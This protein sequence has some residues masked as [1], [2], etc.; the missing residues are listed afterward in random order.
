MKKLQYIILFLAIGLITK[1][2]YY[3]VINLNTDKF[4]LL[5]ADVRAIGSITDSLEISLTDIQI[6]ENNDLITPIEFSAPESSI[7]PLSITIVLDNSASMKGFK[8]DILKQTAKTF[9]QNLPLEVTEVAVATF[10]SQI[11]LW[12]DFTHNAIKLNDAIDKMTPKGGTDFNSAFLTPYFGTIDIAKLGKYRRVVIFITD[13]LSDADV[14]KITNKAI[15]DSIEINCI[16]IGLPMSD[17]LKDIANLTGG[18]HYSELINGNEIKLAFEK[19]YHNIQKT[20]YG[21]L[22]WNSK[23][24]CFPEKEITITIKGQP[25]TFKFNI[26]TSQLGKIEVIPS[27]LIFNSKKAQDKTILIKG[28]NTELKISSI[29]STNESIFNAS[30]NYFPITANANQLIPITLTYQPIDTIFNIGTFNFVNENC[31]DLTVS[32]SNSGKKKLKILTPTAD[33]IYARNDSINISWKGI[34]LSTPVDFYYQIEGN[35]DWKKSV[36][37]THYKTT[38][39]APNTNKKIRIKGL[40]T[41]NINS[42]NLYN[43]PNVI[44][45]ESGFTS[46]QV[47]KTSSQILTTNAAGV[48]ESW[49]SKTGQR[50]NTFE[51]SDKGYT[52]FYPN[53]KRV[54]SF[55]ENQFDIFTNRNGL[56]VKNISL[57][58]KKVLSSYCYIDGQEFYTS[59]HDSENSIWDPSQNI[60]IQSISGGPYDEAA[61]SSNGKYFICRKGDKLHVFQNNPIKKILAVKTDEGFKKVILHNNKGYFVIINKNNSILYNIVTEEIIGEFIHEDFIQF[62]ESDKLVIFHDSIQTKI[63]DLITG[64]LLQAILVNEKFT[65]PL[66]G[67]K[68]AINKGNK[69]VVKDIHSNKTLYSE[70]YPHIIS[71]AFSPSSNKINTQTQDSLFVYNL[72]LN[73][74]DCSV[75][76][77]SKEIRTSKFA[78][79]DELLVSTN[80]LVCLWKI[81]TKLDADTS[82]YF[83]ILL[84]QPELIDEII[85]PAKYVDNSYDKVFFNAIKNKTNHIVSID[86]IYLKELGSAFHIISKTKNLIL[87][88]NENHP[89]EIQFN[90]TDIKAYTNTIIVESSGVKHQIKI[91]GKGIKKDFLLLLPIC[92]FGTIDYGKTK[93]T[94]I[95]ILKNTGSETIHISGVKQLTNQTNNFKISSYSPLNKLVSGDSLKVHIDF[96]PDSRGR[97]NSQL[98]ILMDGNPPQNSTQ[99]IGNCQAKRELVLHVKSMDSKTRQAIPSEVIVTELISGRIVSSGNS[100]I[101]GHY[102]CELNTDLNYS[103]TAQKNGYFSTSE[104]IDLTK[105]QTKD[106]I[107]TTI[108]LNSIKNNGL[109]RLNNI[110]FETASSELL[111]ISKTELTRLINFLIENKNTNLEI[112]GHTDD[113]GTIESNYKLSKLRAENVKNHMLSK[114]IETHRISIKYF[115]ETKP[116]ASNDYNDGKKQ[117]RRVE[118]KL[119][120]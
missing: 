118:I 102:F 105:P 69:L 64:K 96:M 52:G 42:L 119:I 85:F 8:F 77:N 14:T 94:L 56:L 5:S 13:G 17:Q 72:K 88:K 40:V 10:N 95:A 3:K 76:C 18:N 28:S 98:S 53:F 31:P 67:N 99:L 62:H 70:N 83:Q 81:E 45:S 101:Q 50:I 107:N 35:N 54:V 46:V 103:V 48:I 115:G 114:G 51:K 79:E 113:V 108:V 78:T 61:C 110:F 117:N 21:K 65:L 58:N 24:S 120:H 38:F 100:N 90:P 87:A 80:N 47:N 92:N 29:T 112:H 43:Q 63:Y 73:K 66:N 41:N 111:D 44:I 109:I 55:S 84:A 39:T 60:T 86:S 19:I 68:I 2:Q 27:S 104:N 9:I 57:E 91:S 1:A 49:D 93:D 106:T 33:E 7:L 25:T 89:I 23:Y 15:A 22:V 32:V 34:D 74:Y 4:P 36:S 20:T 16:T 75:E 59:A 97:K 82:D 26:P 30:K 6:T 116:I 37:G 71:F 11:N 12:S